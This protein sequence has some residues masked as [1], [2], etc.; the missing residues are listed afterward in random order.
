MVGT[1]KLRPFRTIPESQQS[2]SICEIRGL[3]TEALIRELRELARNRRRFKSTLRG[4]AKK[5]ILILMLVSRQ[6]GAWLERAL[7]RFLSKLLH[8]IYDPYLRWVVRRMNRRLL[9][10]LFSSREL[11]VV[12]GPFAGMKYLPFSSDGSALIPKLLGA[13]ELELHGALRQIVQQEYDT[14]IDIGCAEGYYLVGLTL[15][16]P[17]VTAYGFD[18]DEQALDTCRQLAELNGVAERIHLQ[19][20]CTPA[21]L[22]SASGRK[23]LIIC[24]CEGAEVE[25]LDPVKVPGLVQA[26]ILVELHDRVVPGAAGIIKERFARGHDTTIIGTQDR[27]PAGFPLLAPLGTKD[28]RMALE[29]FRGGPMEWAFL[30]ARPA[31]SENIRTPSSAH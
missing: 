28:Q 12:A 6:L 18:L 7:P 27:D 2:A 5:V 23:T 24:D 11:I 3:Q 25:L 26:D 15:K 8:R 29:E 14:L 22:A 21:K 16:M 4:S 30:R 31:G 9:G 1:V 19:G 13:Y 20:R 10:E 17:R